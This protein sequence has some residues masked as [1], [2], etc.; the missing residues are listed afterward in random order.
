MPETSLLQGVFNG[1]VAFSQLVRDALEA[2][3]RE[4]WQKMIWSDPN[5]EDWPLRERVVV[6]SLYAWA[7]SGRQ[8]TLLAHSYESVLRYQ[9]RMVT[10]RKTWGHI[11]DC[12]VCRHIELEKFP[13]G[14]WS[15]EWVMQ[16]RDID[17]C[18]GFASHDVQ[19]RVQLQ[20]IFKECQRHSA[21]G[22]P[23]T[24]LGL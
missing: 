19:K 2:A 22:F 17:S 16:R 13:S 8:L 12:R 1:H 4:G 18:S 20:E 14:L 5:F 6:D 7:K 10:W 21:S 15:P 3:A 11:V 24:V 9:P 23:A